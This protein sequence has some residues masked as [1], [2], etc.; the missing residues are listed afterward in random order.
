[1]RKNIQRRSVLAA[2]LASAFL[3]AA[4][5]S[6]A[7]DTA[8]IRIAYNLPK[9]HATGLYFETL[10]KEIDKLTAPT[11]LHLKPRTFP[12]GQLYNDTQLPDAVSTGA[13]EKIG[14]AHV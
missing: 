11:A 7:A 9:D 10:A 8:I 14:R 3:W 1:M 12:N 2:G 4:V 5:P 6:H 13:V